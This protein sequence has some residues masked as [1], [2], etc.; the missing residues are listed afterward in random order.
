MTE[1]Q[2]LLRLRV[3]VNHA[4]G[5]RAW[6]R[7]NGFSAAYVN[8]VLLGRRHLADKICDAIG[9]KR[10]ITYCVKYRSMP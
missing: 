6:A 2:V 10:E 3:H 9:I 7:L 5:Q 8:D 1:E 4:G